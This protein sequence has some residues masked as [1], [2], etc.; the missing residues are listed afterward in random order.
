MTMDFKTFFSDAT[1]FGPYPWQEEVATRGLPTLLSV[2]TGL[3]KTEG[4]VLAWAW[5][6]L[7]GQEADEPRHVVYCLPMRVLVQQ[8][9]QRLEQ[10]FQRLR[11]KHGLTVSVHALMGGDVDEEWARHPEEPWVVVGT[12]DMLLSRALNRGY[13]M[14]RFEWPVHFGL[15]NV[16]CRW[17]VDEVQLM[18]PGL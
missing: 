11:D 15:L 17:I 3:G 8:T 2:P 7:V 5:R 14:S 12:Q 6:R 4:A 1:T 16:D 18:G 10:C 9:R 13:S